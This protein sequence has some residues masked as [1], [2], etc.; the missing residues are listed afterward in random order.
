MVPESDVLP[1]LWP[2]P[3]GALWGVGR[4][5]AERLRKL[6]VATVGD[7]ATLPAAVLVGALGRSVGQTLHSLA[8]GR[9]ERPVISD[10]VVK[11]IGHEETYP[12]DVVDRAW[13]E[14]QLVL[15]A[16]QVASRV[17]DGGL[18]A[19]TVVE[20][21]LR[22]L[23]HLDQ[24]PHVRKTSAHR[25]RTVDCTRALLDEL[26]LKDG[27]RLLGV[28][29]SGLLPVGDAPGQQLQLSP[30]AEPDVRSAH[31]AQ[32][33][34]AM[35][36]VRARFGAG[37]LRPATALAAPAAPALPTPGGRGRSVPGGARQG[38]TR[39]GRQP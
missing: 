28:S 21:P 6:G 26:P 13:L 16:D 11:S 38:R 3:V 9:D 10:R 24:E 7:L 1:F 4:A 39:S 19:R 15:M 2:L 20:A 32:A 33:S 31:W 35:D 36:A 12:T 29:A 14:R 5:S 18:V 23:R 25:S 37:A 34:Q 22:Q 30:E 8:W 17:R 27:V